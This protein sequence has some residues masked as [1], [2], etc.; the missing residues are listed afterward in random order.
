MTAL[1]DW[2]RDLVDR[3]TW[4]A[5][6]HRSNDEPIIIVGCGRSGTSLLRVMLDAHPAIACGPESELFL[7]RSPRRRRLALRFDMTRRRVDQLIGRSASLG[8]FI[9]R[10]MRRYARSRGKPRWAEK[11]PRNVHHLPFVFDTFPRA[12]VIHVLRDGR[13]VVCSLRVHP[14]FRWVD[15]VRQPRV[16]DRPLYWCARR[17]LAA[18]AAI[19]PWRADPRVHELRY[20]ALTRDPEGTLRAALAFV[21]EPWDP[22]VLHYHD[23]PSP[24]HVSA[25]IPQNPESITPV[26]TSSIGRWRRDLT[27]QEQDAVHQLLGDALAARGY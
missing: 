20:E 15:G 5:A 24:S 19:A 21:G 11:T 3:A 17:W 6:P 8:R 4:I 18:Q 10:F 23:T 14:K 22:A 12:R 9:E 25:K 27:P 16:T 2:Y 13:D 26:F 7:Q 1:P